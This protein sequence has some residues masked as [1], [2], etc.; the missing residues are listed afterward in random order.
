MSFAREL[1]ALTYLLHFQRIL[2][3]AYSLNPHYIHRNPNR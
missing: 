1:L 2:E 3:C